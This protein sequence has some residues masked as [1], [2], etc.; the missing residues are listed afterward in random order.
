MADTREQIV[1]RLRLLPEVLSKKVGEIAKAAGVEPSTWSNYIA[2]PKVS[3]N[4]IPW[5]VASEL[6][7]AFGLTLDWIYC[8]D[9]PSIKD[10]A[11]RLKIIQ[12]ERAARVKRYA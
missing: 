7:D 9:R 4:V 11:L 12:A 2:E 3:K 10:E 8:G 1:F 5:E 6:K